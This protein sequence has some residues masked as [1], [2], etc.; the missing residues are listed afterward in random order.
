M[1]NGKESAT[2]FLKALYKEAHPGA[3]CLAHSSQG[4]PWINEFFETQEALVERANRLQGENAYYTPCSFNPAPDGNFER[5]GKFVAAKP[6]LWFD[7]DCREEAKEEE[8]APAPK[9][10]AQKALPTKRECLDFIEK[11]LPKPT[12]L[13][14]SGHGYHAYWLFERIFPINGPADRE[15]AEQLSKGFQSEV[16]RKANQHGWKFDNTSDLSRV[17]RLPGSFNH[18]TGTPVPVTLHSMDENV[19]YDFDIL[20]S[21]YGSQANERPKAKGALASKP[22]TVP[23][24]PSGFPEAELDEILEK[25]PFMRHCRD[26]AASLPEPEWW[27]SL[28]V[29]SRCRDG[30]ERCHE[31]SKPHPG[32]S[33]EETDRKI[34]QALT[35]SSPWTCSGIL[36][37]FGDAYC[38]ECPERGRVKSPISLGTTHALAK[39]E[40]PFSEGQLEIAPPPQLEAVAYRIPDGYRMTGEGISLVSGKKANDGEEIA[41]APIFITGRHENCSSQDEMTCLVWL[42]NGKWK[43]ILVPRGDIADPRKLIEHANQGFPVDCNNVRALIDFLVKSEDCNLER[44]PVTVSTDTLGWHEDQEGMGFVLGEAYIT[45]D[46]GVLRGDDPGRVVFSPSSDGMAQLGKAFSQKGDP[47]KWMN[48]VDMI[49]PFPVAR[50]ALLTAIASPLLRIFD[51][52]GFTLDLAYTTSSGKTTCQRIAA[53]VY[54]CPL[55]YRPNSAVFSWNGTRVS[56]ERTAA[57]LSG[58]PFVLNDSKQAPRLEEAVQLIYDVNNGQGKG[59]GAK[60][61]LQARSIIQSNLIS[62]GEDPIADSSE[63]GGLR[64]RAITVSI[65][66]FGN[67]D[68]ADL[69]KQVNAVLTSHYGHAGVSFVSHVLSHQEDWPEW[70]SLFEKCRDGYAEKAEGN[71]YVSRLAEPFGLIDLA[72]RLASQAWNLDEPLPSP[73]EELWDSLTSETA[74]A[75]RSEQALFE[76][77][78]RC[79][80]NQSHFWQKGTFR[81]NVECW[82]R[83]DFGSSDCPYLGI[84][85]SKAKELLEEAG[86]SPLSTIKRWKEKGYLL[87]DKGRN[88]KNVSIQDGKLAKMY[89]IQKAALETHGWSSG[90]SQ[91]GVQGQSHRK[92]DDAQPWT[93]T[94]AEPLKEAGGTCPPEVRRAQEWSREDLIL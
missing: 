11:E 29:V 17:L 70:K 87:T 19:R 39:R 76:V 40:P 45:P 93:P 3:F 65:P 36:K 47:E 34:G 67:M 46:G 44:L 88:D 21:K 43:E 41:S 35:D 58:L 16:I 23:G 81:L 86:H 51:L 6:G 18:K 57:V 60:Q 33:R 78:S 14:D 63:A 12:I 25:C 26:D 52:P 89:V 68:K 2:R 82:G 62:S 24:A 15:R 38:R 83:W 32:Y 69:V 90:V 64:V 13:V 77:V 28:S 22:A 5:K 71:P 91:A 92:Q 80:S 75:D 49:R 73:I 56:H 50:L 61:G 53:S 84:N 1:E 55:E 54:G 74:N 9:V 20:Y 37:S 7:F 85:T 4:T 42:R 79:C 94:V 31:L 10:H 72:A 30:R 66:P 8:G 59:R 48:V 27:A